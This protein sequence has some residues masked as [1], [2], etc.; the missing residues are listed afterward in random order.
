MN[1]DKANA[2]VRY[3]FGL[4]AAGRMAQPYVDVTD[5]LVDGSLKHES[6]GDFS[7]VSSA[8]LREIGG[9]CTGAVAVACTCRIRIGNS[10]PTTRRKRRTPRWRAFGMQP[11]HTSPRMPPR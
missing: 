11:R 8:S 1:R 7:W 2:V 5:V 10:C 3:A 4:S 9:S 6:E